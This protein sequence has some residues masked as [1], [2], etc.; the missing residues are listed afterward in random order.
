MVLVPL[1]VAGVEDGRGRFREI[2]CTVLD[3]HGKD[4]PDYRSC[5]Q[6]LTRVG[7]EPPGSGQPVD[8]GPSSGDFL[9]GLV[10]GFGW[11]CFSNWLDLT[12]SVPSHLAKF[13][14]AFALVDVGG[15][16]STQANAE[17]IRNT[18]DGLETEHDG[19]P[20]ILIG[21][22]KGTP[23]ILEFLVNHP[24]QAARVKA[25]IS[26][27]GSVGG[28]P[29]AIGASQDQAE[30]LL[31]VPGAE[32]DAGDRGA[33]NSLLPE[34]RK[35]WLAENPLPKHISYYSVVSY[36]Q[37]ERISAGLK[38]TYNKLAKVD[39][40]NDSQVLFYD[41]VI[42]GSTLVAYT[43]ADHWAM[44]VPINRSHSF[45]GSTFANRNDYPREAFYEALLRY[46]EEDLASR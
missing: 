42:P 1:N 43:N 6:A 9:V 41:Q 7:E 31:K 19:R 15:L 24:Q 26:V 29:L 11:K 10:P 28:S 12:N 46:V 13:G 5:E 36:P 44:A 38:S 40:R 8:L 17:H 18:I 22:S 45:I 4:L 39:S 14:Y 25:V 33:V 32:C 20:I 2:L 35:R 30:L 21:Y 23:D 27:S 34:V 37:P 16:S 3:T